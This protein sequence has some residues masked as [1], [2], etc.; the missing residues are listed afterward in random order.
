[1]KNAI[2]GEARGEGYNGMLMVGKTIAT[3]MA[4]GYKS[5]VCGVVGGA[6]YATKASYPS[7][8]SLN[9]Q[10]NANILKAAKTVCAMG[11]QY[12]S[13]FH[14]FKNK[15]ATSWAKKF[16]FVGKIGGHWFFNAPSYVKRF[17]EDDEVD[18]DR[19]LEDYFQD[20]DVIMEPWMIDD[21]ALP[22]AF[23]VEDETI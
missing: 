4:R 3:R 5:S 17:Y 13:H 11:D 9:K 20:P 8:G 18:G 14:S 16:T 2:N 1:M 19:F 23:P 22:P 10:A 7:S 15:Y 6:A 12:V 21:S